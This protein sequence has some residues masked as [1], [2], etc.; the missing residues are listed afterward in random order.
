MAEEEVESRPECLM[1][2]DRV[3]CWMIADASGL[4]VLKHVRGQG[5][6]TGA[7]QWRL[8]R[9]WGCELDENTKQIRAA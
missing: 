7:L 9:E 1:T 3:T 4:E 2:W 6:E 5:C 8:A